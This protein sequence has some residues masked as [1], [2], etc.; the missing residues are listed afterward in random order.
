MPDDSS[1]LDDLRHL[2]E[3]S[4]E[5]GRV[6]TLRWAAIL[7][8][9]LPAALRSAAAGNVTMREAIITIWPLLPKTQLPSP[10]PQPAYL[11]PHSCGGS[12]LPTSAIDSTKSVP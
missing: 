3:T 7:E 1:F 5:S 12:V 11:L 9:L 8:V 2:K 6:E 4:A 10:L